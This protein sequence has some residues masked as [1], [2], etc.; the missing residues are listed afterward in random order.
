VVQ[1][2]GRGP[3]RP[4]RV[5]HGQGRLGL[6]DAPA[7]QVR[8]T[9]CTPEG[10][11][12][13]DGARTRLGEAA[14][15]GLPLLLLL[16]E[17]LWVLEV[18]PQVAALIATLRPHADTLPAEPARELLARL[19]GTAQ[20][21][22]L[23]LGAEVAG[24]PV[25]ADGT[26]RLRLTRQP[27]EGL[28]VEPLVRPLPELGSQPAGEGPRELYALRDGVPIHARRSLEDERQRSRELLQAL[29]LTT[30]G[31]ATSQILLTL[32]AALDLLARLA[33]RPPDDPPVAW[34]AARPRPATC[35]CGSATARAG[36]SSAESWSWTA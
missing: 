6:L 29:G 12:L 27:G 5:R 10:Q 11:E 25:P 18:P 35:G 31:D 34:G 16:G 28:L 2:R 15:T 23:H 8:L 20:Q 32:D 24:E 21:L 17:V 3:V 7:G 30:S 4:V 1:A 19:L 22:P 26:V 13:P 33:A 36:S 14:G 9:C